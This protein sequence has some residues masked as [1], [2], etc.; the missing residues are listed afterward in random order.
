MELASANEKKELT[1]QA[2]V[3]AVNSRK[4]C[5]EVMGTLGM[6]MGGGRATGGGRPASGGRGRA[7]GGGGGGL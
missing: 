7:G 3:G 4:R 1:Y 2:A 6:L 5:C